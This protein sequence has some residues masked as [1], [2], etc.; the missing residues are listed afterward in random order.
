MEYIEYT[1]EVYTNGSKYWYKEGKLHRDDGPA[2]EYHNGAKFWYKEDKLHRE[3]GP[4]VES[5]NGHKYWYKEG[6]RHRED[7]PAIEYANGCKEWYFNDKKLSEEEFNKITNNT[8]CDGKIVEID[9]KEYKL[10]EV[11]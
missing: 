2:V 8:S 10:I 1:V 11:P 5:V 3:D 9:G 6:N 7:G 4:A